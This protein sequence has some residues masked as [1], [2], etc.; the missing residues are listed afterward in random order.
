M[1]ITI[2]I[3]LEF[4]IAYLLVIIV[5]AKDIVSLAT[6]CS[7]VLIWDLIEKIFENRREK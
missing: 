3:L 7:I 2:K 4:V 6:G 1:K 5:G